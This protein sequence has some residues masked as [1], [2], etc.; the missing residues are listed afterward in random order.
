MRDGVQERILEQRV[1][2]ICQRDATKMAASDA[3]YKEEVK[4]YFRER[5]YRWYH[6]IPDR[7]REDPFYIFNPHFWKTSLFSKSSRN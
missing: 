5:G 6:I 4:A 7:I 1:Y 3:G 2:S